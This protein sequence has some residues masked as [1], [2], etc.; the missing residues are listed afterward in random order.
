MARRHI[1]NLAALVHQRVDASTDRG[2]K[3]YGHSKEGGI[4]RLARIDEIVPHCK[5]CPDAGADEHSI[6]QSI[7]SRGNS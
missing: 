3:T 1:E 4:S 6:Q 7:G 2:P 5:S